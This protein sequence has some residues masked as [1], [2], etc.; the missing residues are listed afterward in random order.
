ML[1]E[2]SVYVLWLL[3]FAVL[4]QE[5]QDR[6]GSKVFIGFHNWYQFYIQQVEQKK[7]TKVLFVPP[8]NKWFEKDTQVV[9]PGFQ[10]LLFFF[11]S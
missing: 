3:T 1:I 7:I 2:M 10:R 11:L 9:Y 8:Q 4:G 5:G 6:K